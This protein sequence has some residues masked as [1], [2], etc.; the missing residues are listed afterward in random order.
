MNKFDVD[1]TLVFCK[2]EASGS[3]DQFTSTVSGFP[4][5]Q[6]NPDR[7]CCLIR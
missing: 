7:I 5:M 6:S 3:Q 2:A 4:L 1:L